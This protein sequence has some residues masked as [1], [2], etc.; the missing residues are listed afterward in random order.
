MATRISRIPRC[1]A[2]SFIFERSASRL[3]LR[4]QRSIEI[5][6]LTSLINNFAAA[7][8]LKLS[9]LCV[10]VI[11]CICFEQN[12]LNDVHSVLSGPTDLRIRTVY[13]SNFTHYPWNFVEQYQKWR[14]IFTD[15]RRY[16][17]FLI[18]N[19]LRNLEASRL[20]YA[21]VQLIRFLC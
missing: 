9:V 16:F 18:T 11:K 13:R 20:P 1:I 4:L 3:Y 6:C 8:V 21:H 12:F 17:C 5:L 19:E 14:P 2:I 7:E 10:C 15:G